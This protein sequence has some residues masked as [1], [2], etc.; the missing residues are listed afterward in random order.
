MNT[1]LF[2]TALHVVQL[3]TDLMPFFGD[4]PLLCLLFL[5]YMIS[6]SLPSFCMNVLH[7]GLCCY[8][9]FDICL[10]VC[11]FICLDYWPGGHGFYMRIACYP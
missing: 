1:T 8:R 2:L 9:Q 7:T 3:G 10:F 11:L 4:Q 5:L 6:E